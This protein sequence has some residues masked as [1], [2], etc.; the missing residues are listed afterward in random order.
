MEDLYT[1]GWGMA[2]PERAFVFVDN[3]DNQRSFAGK[4]DTII[5]QNGLEYMW[6]TACTLAYNYG[7]TRIMSS[8]E[9]ED[10][11]EGRQ[12]GPPH[13]DDEQYT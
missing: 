13:L 7:F 5:Y 6:A 3:H 10:T 8:Y 1:P 4:G 11:D 12:A 9:F 2:T